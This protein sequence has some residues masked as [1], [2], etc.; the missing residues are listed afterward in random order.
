MADAGR[1]DPDEDLVVARVVEVEL[2][3][4]QLRARLP[5]DGGPDPYAHLDERSGRR[6][7]PGAV[8]ADPGHVVAHPLDDSQRLEQPLAAGLGANIVPARQ[9]EHEVAP[10]VQVVLDDR[11]VGLDMHLL[12]GQRRHHEVAG[13]VLAA[14]EPARACRTTGG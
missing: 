14:D 5:G 10:V 11:G 8:L 2:F 7:D 1:L 4:R 13:Q 12:L 6:V 3:D 9:A